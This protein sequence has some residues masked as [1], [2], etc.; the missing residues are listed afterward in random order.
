MSIKTARLVGVEELAA[1]LGFSPTW[2][3]RLA[4]QRRILYKVAALWRFDVEA[5]RG[6]LG[7]GNDEH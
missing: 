6:A 1:L 7:E 2:V 5:V 3:Y 4:Q